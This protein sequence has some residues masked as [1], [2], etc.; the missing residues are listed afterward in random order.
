MPTCASPNDVTLNRKTPFP[1]QDVSIGFP[2]NKTSCEDV[3]V[4]FLQ[5]SNGILT[6]KKIMPQQPTA[7]IPTHTAS[8]NLG[9][10][11]ILL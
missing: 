2:S 11:K 8:W 9:V 5:I 6:K 7:A 3:Q 4:R 1:V 10:G